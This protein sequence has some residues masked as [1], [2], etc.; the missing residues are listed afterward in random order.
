MSEVTIDIDLPGRRMSFSQDEALIF[1]DPEINQNRALRLLESVYAD[2]RAALSVEYTTEE[3][4]S[5]DRD[6]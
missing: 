2:A 6:S 4:E 5:S 1:D 3:G